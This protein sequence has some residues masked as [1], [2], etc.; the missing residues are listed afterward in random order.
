MIDLPIII[1]GAGAAGLI[2][3]KELSHQGR[4][5]MLL[6]AR[7]RVGGRIHTTQGEKYLIEAGA[8]FIHGKLPL[9]IGLLNSY[10]IPF[11]QTSG[12]MARIQNGKV[13]PRDEFV[14][15][16]DKLID[17]MGN[18][19]KDISLSEFLSINF[20]DDK[21]E[22]LRKTATRFAQGFDLADPKTVSTLALYQEWITEENAEQF[23]VKG[24]YS[25][26]MEAMADDCIRQ[27]GE[28][29]LSNEVQK[30]EWEKDKV[31]AH[32]KEGKKYVG[33]KIIITVPL[34]VLQAGRISFA[35]AL[36]QM[37]AI[38]GI[39]FGT[40]IKILLECKKAFW[41]EKVKSIGF[42][43]SDEKVPTWWTQFP[44]QDHVLTGWLGGNTF[45]SSTDDE[46]I[47]IAFQSLANIFGEPVEAIE[48]LIIKSHVFNWSNDSFSLGAY[49]FPTVQ[50]VDTRK[51][52]NEPVAQTI[53]FAGEG[54]YEGATGGT[55]EA[56]FTSGMDVARRIMVER[57]KI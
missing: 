11:F 23:R 32:T 50:S 13:E 33:S 2:A 26:L 30:I 28:V 17:A 57:I 25:T 7:G 5:I 3:A 24:G 16:W 14:D 15:H 52:F 48:S 22:A 6:E 27:G 1:V 8:E 38:D 49:S 12:I 41:E 29:H 10:S 55:V 54:F 18:L 35:P 9:T 43:F 42:I 21:Y 51:I 40:V 4:K 20:S 34:G 31:T 19:K 56:A 45:Q 37:K 47:K 39:G 36:P 46:I 44:G 53:Y